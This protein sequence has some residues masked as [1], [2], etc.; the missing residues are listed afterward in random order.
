M[1]S[2]QFV[3]DGRLDDNIICIFHNILGRP[4]CSCQECWAVTMYQF[5]VSGSAT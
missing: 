5:S 1:H 4:H 3:E 2:D